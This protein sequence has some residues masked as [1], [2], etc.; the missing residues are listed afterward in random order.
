[1]LSVWETNFSLGFR[2]RI[3][4]LSAL[5]L[6]INTSCKSTRKL[7]PS[8][9]R[10]SDLD[11]SQSNKV[12]K[13]SSSII[14]SRNDQ[15]VPP[16]KPN[17]VDLQKGWSKILGQKDHLQGDFKMEGNWDI[18]YNENQISTPVFMLVRPQH[19][20][21]ISIRPA[22]GIEMARV[23][24]RPDSLWIVNRYNKNYWS[25]A[26]VDLET[27]VGFP[28][29]Y[30]WLQEILL[31]GHRALIEQAVLHGIKPPGQVDDHRIQME[32]LQRNR[33]L[34]FEADWGKWPFKVHRL[35]MQSSTS[36]LKIDFLNVFQGDKTS[37]PTHMTFA[38]QL[39]RNNIFLEMLWKEPKFQSVD[40]PTIKIPEGYDKLLINR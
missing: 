2:G 14:N 21:Y 37:L 35:H 32:T 9:T 5:L 39:P 15:P 10:Q 18:T 22:L 38:F 34:S 12:S 6:W 24:I 8:S 36:S 30:R 26:W 7:N 20:I 16:S 11:S 17:P 23:L 4:L 31:H 40:L 3:F 1:M 28:L 25:G 27:S 19:F 33:K 13:D 29:D